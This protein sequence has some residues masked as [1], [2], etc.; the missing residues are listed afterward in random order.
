MQK[1]TR[2]V[3]FIKVMQFF[4]TLVHT[5]PIDELSVQCHVHR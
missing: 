4:S 1:F 3:Q 2:A 5:L